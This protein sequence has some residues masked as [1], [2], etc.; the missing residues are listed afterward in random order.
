MIR[1]ILIAVLSLLI[2]KLIFA[3][4]PI[5]SSNYYNHDYSV[6]VDSIEITG[7]EVTEDFIIL[8]ELTFGIGDTLTPALAEF[9][10]ERIYSLNIFNDVK[11]SPYQSGEI[12][13]LRIAIE[14]SWYIFPIP[15]ITLKDKDWDKISY[16]LAVS[17]RNFRGR[18]E[19]LRGIMALGFDPS[20]GFLYY[21]PNLSY[22]ENI[23]FLADLS[24]NNVTNKSNTAEKIFGRSFEQKIYISR[25]SAGKRFGLYHWLTFT[26]GFDYIETPFY[27]EGINASRDRIDRTLVTGISYVYDTRDLIQYPTDGIFTWFNFELKGHGINDINYRVANLEFR[28]YRKL[29]HK[30]TAKWRLSFRHTAGDLVPFYDYSFI[31]Y[32][33]RI[34]G[35]WSDEKREGN[36]R[37]IGSVELNYPVIEETRLN[38]F[39]IPLL[40]KSLLSYRVAFIAQL[41]AD[42]GITRKT[43]E[44][45]SLNGFDTGYG[46]GFSLLLLPYVVARFELAFNEK[47]QSEW[48]FDLGASF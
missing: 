29:F 5:D 37:F 30:L 12:N 41:F 21:N 48:I 14:E 27:I 46:A 47:G 32:S 43:G 35:Y 45:V 24:F 11:L 3:Y 13:V 25:L 26:L 4:A 44:T 16:G 22:N 10:R 42:T 15:F 9:N 19:K 17:L 33:E 39:F 34:R 18:N 8:R 40:P 31:G 36:D 28:E 20:F 38:L 2:T 23:H 1:L 6:I 7:N